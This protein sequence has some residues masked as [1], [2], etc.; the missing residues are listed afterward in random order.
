MI[1]VKVS[2]QYEGSNDSLYLR[3]GTKPTEKVTEVSN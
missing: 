2:H 3:F 1:G